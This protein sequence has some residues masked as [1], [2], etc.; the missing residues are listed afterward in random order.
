MRGEINAAE[1]S[2]GM[3]QSLL[4]AIQTGA[5]DAVQFPMQ[6]LRDNEI[7][8]GRCSEMF[9]YIQKEADGMPRYTRRKQLRDMPFQLNTMVQGPAMYSWR[10]AHSKDRQL[11]LTGETELRSGCSSSGGTAEV[12]TPT[13]LISQGMLRVHF[14]SRGCCSYNIFNGNQQL[15]F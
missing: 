7:R 11:R 2:Q 9:L 6:Q 8:L 4:L 13:L 12:M 1:I 10:V 3:C 14:Y 15:P 5:G